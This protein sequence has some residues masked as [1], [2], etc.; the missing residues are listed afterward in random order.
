MSVQL[1]LVAVATQ[2][3]ADLLGRR[4][5]DGARTTQ[6]TLPLLA[7][8]ACQMA[9]PRLAVLG[10]ARS[11]Q[12]KTLLCTLVSFLFWHSNLSASDDQCQ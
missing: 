8:P 9:R 6:V 1:A 2:G 10:L 4:L 5:V 3:T 11:S 7:H 12:T